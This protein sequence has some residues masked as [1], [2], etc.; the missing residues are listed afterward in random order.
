M[1]SAAF[2][3]VSQIKA[4]TFAFSSVFILLQLLQ[5]A[6]ETV[7]TRTL[8]QAHLDLQST[9]KSRVFTMG[10]GTPVDSEP[11]NQSSLDL[12]K[13]PIDQLTS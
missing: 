12:L 2:K 9:S 6:S 3:Y 11:C 13:I 10:G 1:V 5:G 8:L 7:I 4:T